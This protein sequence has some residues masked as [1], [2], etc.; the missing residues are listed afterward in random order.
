[1][2]LPQAPARYALLVGEPLGAVGVGRLIAL[3]GAEERD[4]TKPVLKGC[5][6]AR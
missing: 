4:D 6:G 5:D 2:F 1:M 3:R